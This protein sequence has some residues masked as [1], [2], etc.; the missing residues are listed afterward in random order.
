[1]AAE[2]VSETLLAH[3]IGHSPRTTGGNNYNRRALA[4]GEERELAERRQVLEREVPAVTIHVPAPAKVNLLHLNK[5]SRVGS[6]QGRDA[7]LYFLWD[8]EA[9]AADKRRKAGARSQKRRS[10]FASLLK[11]SCPSASRPLS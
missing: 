1:M 4:L 2:D 10:G 11:N 6:A 5:R 9:I 3:H 7:S 8:A